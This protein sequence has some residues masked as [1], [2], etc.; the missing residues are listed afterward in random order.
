MTSSLALLRKTGTDS[1]T[2]A[3]W[4]RKRRLGRVLIELGKMGSR[5]PLDR[6]AGGSKDK[7][8]IHRSH[9][10]HASFRYLASDDRSE[11]GAV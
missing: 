9:S 11:M 1:G 2:T 5:E 8:S 7:V 10:L 4:E 6:S 3:T